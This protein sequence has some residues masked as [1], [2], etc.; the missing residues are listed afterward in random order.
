V[1]VVGPAIP[2]CCGAARA[3]ACTWPPPASVCDRRLCNWACK[4]MS[5]RRCDP[6]QRAGGRP[7]HGVL[8]GEQ[9]GLRG[10]LLSDERA[11]WPCASPDTAARLALQCATRRAAAGHGGCRN[12]PRDWLDG[13]AQASRDP[14]AEPGAAVCECWATSLYFLEG[15]L[16][17]VVA[18]DQA[19]KALSACTA[20]RKVA[21]RAYWLC[22]CRSCQVVLQTELGGERPAGIS[23]KMIRSADLLVAIRPIIPSREL[24]AVRPFKPAVA[25]IHSAY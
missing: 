17:A 14:S 9:F 24:P 18:K 16:V 8:A 22:R 1:V 5:S 25:A 13:T 12:L 4:Q 10:D 19:M 23:W 3:A 7:W 6:A 11:C 2:R 20:W 21:L 15:R